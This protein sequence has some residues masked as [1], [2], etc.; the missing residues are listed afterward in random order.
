MIIISMCFTDTAPDNVSEFVLV[1]IVI[2][3]M[4]TVSMQ[5]TIAHIAIF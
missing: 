2:A 1:F 5:T 4:F 3:L